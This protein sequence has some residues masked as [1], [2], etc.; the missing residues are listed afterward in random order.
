M[1]FIT[2]WKMYKGAALSSTF[3]VKLPFSAPQ[4]VNRLYSSSVKSVFRIFF[5]EFLPRVMHACVYMFVAVSAQIT[6]RR[7]YTKASVL[8]VVLRPSNRRR[9]SFE[10]RLNFNQIFHHLAYS[11]LVLALEY[12]WESRT[13]LSC[14]NAI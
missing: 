12:V 3:I 4:Q 7:Q 13:T 14:E 1:G 10:T 2:Y 9:F 6:T 5:P 11:E 8:P